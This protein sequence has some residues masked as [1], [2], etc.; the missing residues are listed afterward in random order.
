VSVLLR[1]AQ[2]FLG[3]EVQKRPLDR[4]VRREE[5]VGSQVRELLLKK[6]GVDNKDRDM[7]AAV[8]MLA[9]RCNDVVGVSQRAVDLLDLARIAVEDQK[10]LA[11]KPRAKAIDHADL[12]RAK[13]TPE[14]PVG[15]PALWKEA[16]EGPEFR[17]GHAAQLRDLLFE[18]LPRLA[19]AFKLRHRPRSIP[20]A[21][22]SV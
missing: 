10:P 18:Q 7:N 14:F 6:A 15:H 19:F 13:K 20:Q 12:W 5:K 9:R 8:L 22:E 3:V 21:Q 17:I 4:T 2:L 16:R 1:Q 11:A